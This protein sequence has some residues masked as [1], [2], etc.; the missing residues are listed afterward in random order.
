[1][2]QIEP[3]YFLSE[4]TQ[5][6]LAEL[7]PNGALLGVINS[8]AEFQLISEYGYDGKAS[9]FFEKFSIWQDSPFTQC[10]RS[11]TT[12]SQK[13]SEKVR[14]THPIINSIPALQRPGVTV[15]ALPLI[16]RLGTIGAV[17]FTFKKYP[18]ELL[19]DESFWDGFGSICTFY[20]VNSRLAERYSKGIIPSTE[21]T[22]RQLK[23]LQCFKEGLTVDHIA[24]LLRFSHSTIRQEIMRIYRK[25]GV[26][27]RKSA[28]HIAHARK[29]I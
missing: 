28:I 25:L 17:G 8:Q 12:V 2:E 24:E 4:I 3:L 23:I 27:D 5:T 18:G 20:L 14:D 9:K 21:L 13:L 19:K 22:P 6:V 11:R 26:Y 15:V 7:E 1:M 10:I 29:I 16:Y